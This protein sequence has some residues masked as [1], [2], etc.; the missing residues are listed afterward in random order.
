MSRLRG[1]LSSS[2]GKPPD[3]LSRVDDLGAL[4][5]AQ[6]EKVLAVPRGN[7]ICARRD[8]GCHDLI[9]IN[10]TGHH[11]RHAFRLDQL[12][13]LDVVAQ[14]CADRPVH[15][16]QS[17]RRR[18][19]AEHIGSFLKLRG[20]AVKLDAGSLADAE[21]Q[22]IRRSAQKQRRQHHV[23]IK[24]DPHLNPSPLAAPCVLRTLHQ[25][26]PRSPPRL[27]ARRR[28]FLMAAR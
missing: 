6:R 3:R 14:H 22:F 27:S 2:G 26:R 20:A 16:S 8:G 23:G 12:D 19:P 9:V 10:I 24:N 13:G 15:Q 1:V 17:L 18:W 21:Q 11:A 4:M 7:Q 5:A 25:P 28:P